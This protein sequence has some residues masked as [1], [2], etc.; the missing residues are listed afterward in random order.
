[1]F[2][3]ISSILVLTSC[4]G[5]DDTVYTATN[6]FVY[7]TA[8][9]TGQKYAVADIYGAVKI[10]SDDF[11][12]NPNIGLGDCAFVDYKIKS[13]E[14]SNGIY[15]AEYIRIYDKKIFKSRDNVIPLEQ[16]FD[17]TMIAK[18]DS[19]KDG[20]MPFTSIRMGYPEL[21]YSPS[22]DWGDRWFFTFSYYARTDDDTKPELI[23]SYDKNKQYN[24]DLTPLA[25]G[26]RVIDF[27]LKPR[28]NGTATGDYKEVLQSVV[29][30]MSE[31]REWMEDSK[32]ENEQVRFIFRYYK[33]YRTDTR[34][35]LNMDITN[36]YFTYAY[37][38]K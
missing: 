30:N 28:S 31:F 18:K 8:A 34:I 15:N 21:L 6:Q 26:L 38:N 3:A 2:V 5:D 20:M 10:T 33:D 12:N 4:L 13:N 16:A 7:V 25:K 36:N 14:K 23:V 1:M 27:Q 29:I 37:M 9:S 22:N 19:L 11:N 35:R 17:T 24:S 32:D